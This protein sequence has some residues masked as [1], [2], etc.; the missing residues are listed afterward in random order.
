MNLRSALLSSTA[1]ILTTGCM[2]GPRYSKPTVATTPSYKETAPDAFK[3]NSAWQPAQPA[4]A[5][6]RSQWWTIFDDAE[7]NTLE[8]RV[9]ID[10]Q[11]LKA[12]EARFRQARAQ[13]RYNRASLA[14]TIG[15]APFA[16]GER[17][18]A[19]RP[20]FNPSSASNT[21]DI[22]LPVDLNYEVD[23]WGRIRRSVSAA[24]EEAQASAADLQT[25]LLS[26]QAELAVDYFEARSADAQEKLLGDTV[27][28]YEEAFRITTNRFEGGVA[29]KSDVEQARTQ[30]EAARVQYADIASIRAQYEHAIAVLLGQPPASFTL[31]TASL[32]AQPPSIPVGLPTQLLERRPDIAAAERRVAEDNDRVGIARAAYYPTLSISAVAG[33][34]STAF[35]N[36]L[37]AANYLWAAGPTASQTLFDFGRRRAVSE[38]AAAGYDE[39]VATYRQ[40]TLTAFQQV[41]DNLAALRVLQ[42]EAQHQHQATQAAQAAEQIF[43][44]RYVGGIDNYLSVVTAQTTALA[45]ERNEI[46]IRR[47]QMDA[48]VL[49][50]KALGGGWDSTQLPKL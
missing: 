14:P 5:V 48:S 8:P 44:N 41:E 6:Q 28:N 31:T 18:S 17:E 36:L 39:T 12:A 35:S 45:N 20:Y 23:L 15:V 11:D 22:Q 33:F 16:G 38:S 10:N 21:G 30:L 27:K 4:D 2:V 42:Q 50:I 9:A 37:S 43:S 26:L 46:D 34:E 25:A 40:T 32:V 7:L 49:L 24:R 29:A 19:N 47:R 13:I 3:E 1:L